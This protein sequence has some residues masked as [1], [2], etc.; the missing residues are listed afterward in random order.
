MV[1]V[2]GSLLWSPM[3]AVVVGPLAAW[4]GVAVGCALA[5]VLWLVHRG[6]LRAAST[7]L[8]VICGLGVLGSHFTFGGLEGWSFVTVVSLPMAAMLLERDSGRAGARVFLA[9]LGLL[10]LSW[11]VPGGWVVE[12][13]SR[14]AVLLSRFGLVLISIA[15]AGAVATYAVRRLESA[16]RRALATEESA[17]RACLRKTSFLANISHELRTPMN[18]ILGYSE[19][20]LEDDGAPDPHRAD[21]ERIREAGA[22]LLE[23]IDQVLRVARLDAG[24]PGNRSPRAVAGLVRRWVDASQGRLLEES[25]SGAPL[26][27]VRV[28]EGRLDRLV[29]DIVAGYRH[30]RIAEVRVATSVVDDVVRVAFRPVGVG[31]LDR[32]EP[33]LVW[34]FAERSARAV[35]VRVLRHD[36]AFIELLLPMRSEG[37]D[38][39]GAPIDRWPLGITFPHLP[40]DPMDAVRTRLAIRL[41]WMSMAIVAIVGPA[42]AMLHPGG[43]GSFVPVV[44]LVGFLVGILWLFRTG[45]N[46]LASLAMAAGLIAGVTTTQALFGGIGDIGIV[47][48][49]ALAVLATFIVGTRGGYAPT[50][51]TVLAGLV[52]GICDRIGLLPAGLPDTRLELVFV[53]GAAT[54]LSAALVAVWSGP[55]ENLVGSASEAAARA[56]E[57]D[58]ATT[59]FLDVVSIELR[60]PLNA[61]LGYSELL[62]EED[63]LDPDVRSD[64]GHIV[65][66]G[67]HLLGVVDDLLDMSA[68]VSDRLE[69]ASETVELPVML[70]SAASVVRPLLDRRRN[71]LDLVVD[72]GVPSVVADERR[73]RQIL[74]NL[75]SN[76]AKFTADGRIEVAVT[77]SGRGR[78][79]IAVRD[80]GIG[81]ATADLR[82]LFEPF[83]QV[84]R[85]NP[86]QYGGTGLGLA[87]SRR[88]ARKMGGDIG[89]RSA[90]GEGSVFTVTLPEAQAG[91]SRMAV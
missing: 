76:A 25:A 9:M 90:L 59:R 61:I 56:S 48:L 15:A 35:G 72:P 12:P 88:L 16:M 30:C 5:G 50:V 73:L 55:L 41:A 4:V 27:T 69:L 40:V 60:T 64:L 78:V 3:G 83:C 46:R 34:L 65:Q 20:L 42:T 67:R 32:I 82:H 8:M 79:G 14:Q 29:H 22:A 23:L 70:A 18:A 66:A 37:S 13:P 63:G 43:V 36:D 24:G 39:A 33:P 49:P 1:G 74:V 19:L 77:R 71:A 6:E 85:G 54:G 62:L 86:G 28:D 38:D 45:R 84:H 57:A 10:G 2:A 21:V 52:L 91:T 75:L 7:T 89:V 11:A 58:R 53:T 68:I 51:F 47:Y 26:T 87:I 31:P 80:T 81:I 17:R 44:A